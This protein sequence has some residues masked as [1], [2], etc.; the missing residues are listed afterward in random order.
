MPHK[1]TWKAKST[2]LVLFLHFICLLFLQCGH[3]CVNL[4]LYLK[5]LESLFSHSSA[6]PVSH[7][8][9]CRSWTFFL[10]ATTVRNLARTVRVRN[11]TGGASPAIEMH[12]PTQLTRHHTCLLRD[13][14]CGTS[15][16]GCSSNNG[17]FLRF[18]GSSFPLSRQCPG[19]LC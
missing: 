16:G 4:L 8:F 9:L 13:K 1:E 18:L 2:R 12:H 3:H 17:M 5:P 15:F 11:T 14:R 10:S 6:T 7:V 19:L